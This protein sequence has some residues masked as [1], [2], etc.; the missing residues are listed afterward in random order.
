MEICPKP[1]G[2]IISKFKNGESKVVIATDVAA[3]GIDVDGIIL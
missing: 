1:K 3:R 2:K